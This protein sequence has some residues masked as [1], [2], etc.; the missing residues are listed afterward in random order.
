MSLKAHIA[1][2]TLL[3]LLLGA[4]AVAVLSRT[5]APADASVEA[6]ERDRASELEDS[7]APAAVSGLSSA[8]EF[9]RPMRPGS[10]RR[11]LQS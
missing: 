3:G 7:V 11:L 4:G 6:S 5:A 10:Q 1:L 8:S 2:G 9:R